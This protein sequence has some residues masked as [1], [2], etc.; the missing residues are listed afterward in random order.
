MDKEAKNFRKHSGN[1]I[2]MNKENGLKILEI[3]SGR[4]Y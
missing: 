1:L 3:Y 2:V 4:T